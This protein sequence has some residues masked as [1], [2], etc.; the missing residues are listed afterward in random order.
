M[1]QSNSNYL[2][3]KKSIL[4][5][6]ANFLQTLQNNTS[7]IIQISS[8]N[9]NKKRRKL[10]LSALD[11][12]KL[13]KLYDEILQIFQR[14][15]Q[16]VYDFH[17]ALTE[18]NNP[19]ICSVHNKFL[20]LTAEYLSPKPSARKMQTQ[21][22]GNHYLSNFCPVFAEYIEENLDLSDANYKKWFLITELQMGYL[23]DSKEGEVE[24]ETEMETDDF[25]STPKERTD[26]FKM[27]STFQ[28]LHNQVEI[29]IEKTQLTVDPEMVPIM[30][31]PPR[32]SKISNLKHKNNSNSTNLLRKINLSDPMFDHFPVNFWDD[33]VPEF[34]NDSNKVFKIYYLLNFEGCVLNSNFANSGKKATGEIFFKTNFTKNSDKL[35]FPELEK[36]MG[37]WPFSNLLPIFTEDDYFEHQIIDFNSDHIYQWPQEYHDLNLQFDEKLP[38]S[39]VS[40]PI[41]IPRT[42]DHNSDQNKFD[43]NLILL[44]YDAADKKVMKIWYDKKTKNLVQ[45][46]SQNDVEFKVIDKDNCLGKNFYKDDQDNFYYHSQAAT[47]VSESINSSLSQMYLTP[48]QKTNTQANTQ[49]S[50]FKDKFTQP[51]TLTPVVEEEEEQVNVNVRNRR[52]IVNN[53]K[54]RRVPT[55]RSSSSSCSSDDDKEHQKMVRRPRKMISRAERHVPKSNLSSESPSKSYRSSPAKNFTNNSS[56]IP[57]NANNSALTVTQFSSFKSSNNKSKSSSNQPKTSTQYSED[58]NKISFLEAPALIQDS[59][60]PEIFEQ[61]ENEEDDVDSM[62]PPPKSTQPSKKIHFSQELVQEFQIPNRHDHIIKSEMHQHQINLSE[63]LPLNFTISSQDE[64]STFSDENHNAN[65]K[66]S[67]KVLMSKNKRYEAKKKILLEAVR[68]IDDGIQRRS[69][70]LSENRA[71]PRR[72]RKTFNL[73]TPEKSQSTFGSLG[74]DYDRII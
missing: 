5:E 56:S 73:D 4:A 20:L 8:Y 63:V 53:S 24:S 50:L 26:T 48:T 31:T 29:D 33:L 2:S 30:E 17:Y 18:C 58:S 64:N 14:L 12:T 37:N 10:K 11:R 61:E 70:K 34:W 27:N 67:N 66:L 68:N 39:I 45:A 55:Q 71:N 9:D 25:D 16:I 69:D 52:L 15:C 47:K 41:K 57:K 38:E 36:Q 60:H 13:S 42:S 51:K 72:N 7:K 44:S 23:K 65:N 3:F 32:K 40:I 1:S 74:S 21:A 6:F 28:L 22:V 62:S 43:N 49:R 54:R 46:G 59:N 35:S 19:V